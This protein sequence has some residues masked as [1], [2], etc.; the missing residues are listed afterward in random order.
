MGKD[1][2][3]WFGCVL[4]F[5]AGAIWG[6]VKAPADFFVIKNVHDLSETIGGFATVAALLAA[7]S[8]INSWKR[9]IRAAE[10]H[11][12]A[13]RLAVSLSKYKASVISS[14]SY[15]RVVVSEVKASD[16]GV[17][18][19]NSEGYR[20]LVRVAR[21]SILLARAEIE[22]IALECVAVWGES[23]EIKFQKILMFE[24][25][26]T[27]CIDR[28]LFWNSGGLSEVDS[29]LFSRGIIAGGVRVNG[30]YAGDYDGVV[31]YVKEITCDIEAALSE[32]LLS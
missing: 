6:G 8:G 16:A 32:K 23:Y 24:D 30:F 19:E 28:Y 31:G 15:V 14:W 7:V 5:G 21:D 3:I 1:W 13:R 27:K 18:I 22:S 9:Q 25:A 2:F 4:L 10:D 29:K 11:D 26:C 17:V 20:N 12:L